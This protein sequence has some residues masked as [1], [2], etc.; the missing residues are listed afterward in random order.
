MLAGVR[1][2]PPTLAAQNRARRL[3]NIGLPGGA[4]FIGALERFLAHTGYS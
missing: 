3:G 4:A 1:D 2:A